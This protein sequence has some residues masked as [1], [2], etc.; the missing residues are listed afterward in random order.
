MIC[1]EAQMENEASLLFTIVVA[2]PGCL[3]SLQSFV[4]ALAHVGKYVPT[5]KYQEPH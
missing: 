1:N 3:Q 5:V 4:S 2:L